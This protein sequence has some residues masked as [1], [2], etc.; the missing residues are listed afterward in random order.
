MK[1]LR[2]PGEE[3]TRQQPFRLLQTH[4]GDEGVRFEGLVE[5]QGEK[6]VL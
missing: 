1:N 4:G 6:L 3:K 2:L 5:L